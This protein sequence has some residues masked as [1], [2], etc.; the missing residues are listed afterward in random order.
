MSAKWAKVSKYSSL[1]FLC[2]GLRAVTDKL[3][4]PLTTA[5]QSREDA[6]VVAFSCICIRE[7]MDNENV[8]RS[9]SH[10]LFGAHCHI[11]NSAVLQVEGQLLSTLSGFPF[12]PSHR[13][14]FWRAL[15]K[16]FFMHTRFATP[17]SQSTSNCVKNNRR[18]VKLLS[19]KS[20]SHHEWRQWKYHDRYIVK[21][22]TPVRDSSLQLV[23][24]HRTTEMLLNC[25]AH[26]KESYIWL[27]SYYVMLTEML[28]AW[29]ST[30][31]SRYSKKHWTVLQRMIYLFISYDQDNARLVS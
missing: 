5:E 18:V 27:V 16:L 3:R 31:G 19:Y 13:H 10:S 30:L 26:A 12:S 23:Q 20:S 29:L 15:A 17:T 2:M 8:L 7:V 25:L 1:P 22:F 9:G 28:L 6:F 4:E 24:Y 21:R 14:F 11:H